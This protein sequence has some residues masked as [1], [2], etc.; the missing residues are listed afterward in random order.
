MNVKTLS[1]DLS[2]ITDLIRADFP[3]FA[4]NKKLVYLDSAS[5]AQKPRV[6]IGAM[7]AAME[8]YANVHRG[9]YGLSQKMTIAYEAARTKVAGFI[10][11][12]TEEIVFTRNATE[13]INL[14]AASWGSVNLKQGDEILITA[15]EHHANIVPWQL[16]AEKTGAK[17]IVAPITKQ[18]D[19]LAADVIARMTSRTK[20]VAISHMSNVL[21]TILPVAEIIAA[22]NKIGAATLIDGCQAVVHM[23]VDVKALGCDFYVFSGH[24][25]YGPTGIGVLYGRREMLNAM[26]PYQGGG[27]M[28]D[29][30]TFEKTTFKNAPARFEAGTP[31][32][33]EAIGLAAA[34]DYIQS[35][36]QSEV[37]AYED[38]IYQS[39][40]IR[41]KA[42]PGIKLY[43]EATNRAS[44]LCFTCDWGH[45]SDI[46]MLLDK[47]NIAVRVG[48][49]CAMPLMREL[50]V[51]AT[52]RASIGMY[53]TMSDI[54][55]LLAGLNK[56]KEML[57]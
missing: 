23:A 21:G 19:V 32:F 26:P 36:G 48:H 52:I 25:L 46:A 45:A 18:G 7:N 47:R 34:I 41:L 30:V 1:D 27:D 54:D 31:A 29:N 20:M 38:V 49:H 44:I 2:S 13:S 43:G 12:E 17:L 28:I 10:Q 9:V 8:N 11:A 4:A 22:A 57:S 50:G 3:V 39:A 55:A 37:A 51:T 53:T 6:V 56:A 15:L 14:V 5:S 33:I 35:Q 42:M 40:Y 24:K 16:I